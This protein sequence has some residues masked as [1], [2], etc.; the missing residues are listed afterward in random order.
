MLPS[1]LWSELTT[2]DLAGAAMADAIAVLPV[3]ATEQ[4]GP[5]LPL[6]TDSFIAQGYLDRVLARLPDDLAVVVLP[7]QTIGCSGEHLAF[8]G[9]LSLAAR[10]ALDAWGGLIGDV[11]RTGCRKLVVVNAHGGNSSVLDLLALEARAAHGLLVVLA[12]WARLGTPPGLFS[13]AEHAHGI[14]GGQIETSLMLCF[15]PDLVRM[16][17]ARDFPSAS[18]TLERDN[19][20]LRA[21]GR[22][23][24][25]GWMAQDLNPAGTVGNAAAATAEAGH[26]CA[27]HGAEAFIALL[28][29]VRRF[30]MARLGHAHLG[31][32]HLGHGH[33]GSR[34]GAD[35]EPT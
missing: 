4:H 17:A 9:T 34:P 28:H 20:W 2:V 21:F 1:R 19:V 3:A 26:A 27:E 35:R 5:H 30:D 11:A 32:A 18:A 25:L 13:D 29:D 6:G 12:S 33:L 7:L 8:P 15:R 10:T 24:G 23:T 14:H 16:A 22:P 31:H